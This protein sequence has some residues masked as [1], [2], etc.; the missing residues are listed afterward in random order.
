M[1]STEADVRGIQ[2][3]SY[4]EAMGG[5]EGLDAV[6]VSDDARCQLWTG[7]GAESG[8]VSIKIAASPS[9]EASGARAP[10]NPGGSVGRG[11]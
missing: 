5:E 3:E 1:F 9:R 8:L 2:V 11:S 10:A 4:L 7:S 6:R